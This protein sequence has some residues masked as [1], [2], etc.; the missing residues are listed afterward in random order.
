MNSIAIYMEGGGKGKNSKAALRQGMDE[1]L[2][3][4]KESARAKKWRWKL[5]PCGSRNEAFK[6]FRRADRE[7]KDS[8]VVLLVDSEGPVLGSP[9]NHVNGRDRWEVTEISNE[10]LHLMIQTMESWIVS[11]PEAMS[12]YYGQGFRPN[13][14]PAS[15]NLERVNKGDISKALEKATNLTRKGSYHKIK[16]AR[17]LLQ[18]ID[19]RKV[20]RECPSCDRLFKYLLGL[21]PEG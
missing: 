18:L 8:T 17:D 20:R 15:S 1:F 19:P 12:K 9:V 2:R 10:I 13:A 16:H 7:M 11:D 6:S 21:I 4:I 14:L 3:E 5:V